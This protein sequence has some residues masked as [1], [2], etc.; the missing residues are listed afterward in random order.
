[1][2]EM[3]KKQFRNKV[4]G[5]SKWE[6]E[7]Y[8]DE[9]L[10]RIKMDASDMRDVE[11]DMLNSSKLPKTPKLSAK[12]ARAYDEW[13]AKQTKDAYDDYEEYRRIAI[14]RGEIDEEGNRLRY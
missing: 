10:M 14:D 7:Q 13:K 3:H 4:K 11:K 12:D 1:M 6:L 9:Y 5:V 2:N 8:P